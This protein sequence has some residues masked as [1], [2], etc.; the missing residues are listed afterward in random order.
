MG[1]R[2]TTAGTRNPLHLRTTAPSLPGRPAAP[3]C[4]APP[5]ASVPASARLRPPSRPRPPQLTAARWWWRNT[6]RSAPGSADNVKMAAVRE[7]EFAALQRLLRVSG[8]PSYWRTGARPGG[9]V[10]LSLAAAER[11][12]LCFP[13]GTIEGCRAAAVPAMFLQPA[14]RPCRVGTARLPQPRARPGGSGAGKAG[15]AAAGRAAG[16]ATSGMPSE[17]FSRAAQKRGA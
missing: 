3:L 9:G 1:S 17:A 4:P 11:L 16:A 7:A 2:C 6:G 8:P 12:P 13:P 10:C 14:R 5:P 15:R